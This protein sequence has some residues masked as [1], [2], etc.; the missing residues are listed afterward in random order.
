[1]LTDHDVYLFREGTHGRLFEGLG[2]QMHR[3][4]DG[5]SFS[6]WAPHRVDHAERDRRHE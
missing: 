5:A 6:V 1:M 4:R 3:S 2:C